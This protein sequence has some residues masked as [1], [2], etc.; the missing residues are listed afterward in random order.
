MT[1]EHAIQT[2]ILSPVLVTPHHSQAKGKDLSLELLKFVAMILII[3]VHSYMM[4]PPKYEMFATGGTIGD[5]LFMFCSG[6]T[7]FLGRIDRFDNWY[8]RRINRIYP[9]VFAWAIFSFYC[10]ADDMNIGQIVGGASRWFIPC[11]M[12]Y[13]VLL[14]FVRKYLMRFKWW[15]FVVACIIPIVRF[16]MYEDI[17]LSLI[18]I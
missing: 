14:Y 16:V 15:V 6:Y 12:M 1:F 5:A 2:G 10:F 9:S 17:G 4:Y 7:L 18:H 11:I 3:N 8:K 13:Y